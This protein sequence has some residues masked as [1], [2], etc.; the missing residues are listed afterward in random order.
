M[1]RN[2]RW[3][4]EDQRKYLN[5]DVTKEGNAERTTRQRIRDRTEAAAKDMAVV[6]Q[7]LNSQDVEL[8]FDEPRPVTKH[9]AATD[10]DNMLD[11]T[12]SEYRDRAEAVDEWTAIIALF[13]KGHWL[14]NWDF[15]STLKI[16]VERAHGEPYPHQHRGVLPPRRVNE[17]KFTFDPA[18]E[19]IET[20]EEKQARIEEKVRKQQDPLTDEERLFYIEHGYWSDIEELR[21]F[22][23]QQRRLQVRK[24]NREQFSKNRPWIRDQEG[25]EDEEGGT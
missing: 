1:S 23:E 11:K 8:L 3:L 7:E 13:Y 12:L 20:K 18:L 9:K 10:P 22:Q 19:P 2:G 25:E 6:A 21:E 16:A 15:G 4:T 5:G 17:N 24:Y 14:K